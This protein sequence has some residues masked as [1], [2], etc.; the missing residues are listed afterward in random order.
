[1][2]LVTL[3]DYQTAVYEII[4]TV[5]NSVGL[6]PESLVRKGQMPDDNKNQLLQEFIVWKRGRPS[7]IDKT[8]IT[9][10]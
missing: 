8:T 6:D 1:M 10:H 7:R 9:I 2:A 5:K 3:S 4:D